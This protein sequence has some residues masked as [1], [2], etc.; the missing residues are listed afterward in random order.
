MAGEKPQKVSV[1]FIGSQVLSGRISPGE[2]SKL[3]DALGTEGWRD[4]RFEDGTVALDLS[5]VVYV[6]VEDEEHRVG[7]G[8]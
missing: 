4:V 6:L 7:F 8:A 3:R 1:G 5:K 2:L